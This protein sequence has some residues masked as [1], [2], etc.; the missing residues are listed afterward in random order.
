ME[1]KMKK[2]IPLFVLIGVFLVAFAVYIIVNRLGMATV[3]AQPAGFWLGLWQGLIVILAFIVSWFDTSIT[4]YQAGNNGFWYNLGYIFGLCIAL[5]SGAR[6]SRATRRAKKNEHIQMQTQQPS[7]PG[8]PLI[9]LGPGIA[10]A[11]GWLLFV[12]LWLFFYAG[13]YSILQNMGALLI[14]LAALAILEAVIWIPW[15]MKQPGWG[16]PPEKKP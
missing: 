15:A 5:G 8:P 9:I 3:S 12:G 13:G 2:F 7:P 1:E 4:I 10:I 6:G 11:F 16:S 14:S